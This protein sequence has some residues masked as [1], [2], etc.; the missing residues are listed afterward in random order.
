MTIVLGLH[1]ILGRMPSTGI[2]DAG[3]CVADPESGKILALVEAE[4]VSGIKHDSRLAP[5]LIREEL[6]A[7]G[8]EP[9]DVA[10]SHF[11][12]LN[13][14]SVPGPFPLFRE[15]DRLDKSCLGC[16]DVR[17]GMVA[18]KRCSQ[19]L[20]LHELA[21]VFGSFMYRQADHDR[22]LGL[23]IEGCGSFAQNSLFLVEGDRTE[24]LGYNYPVLS[25]HF[26]H[27]WISDLA[28]DVS[29]EDREA[30]SAVPGKAM[31]L[32]AYGDPDRFLP[33]LREA[34]KPFEPGQYMN[35]RDAFCPQIEKMRLSWKDRADL[36]A[37]GQALFEETIEKLAV[38][39]RE[40]YGQLP[41]YYSGGCA[42]SIK[43]N[44]RLKQ[45][46]DHLVV[47]P[48]CGDDGLALGLASMHAFM[49]YGQRLDPL[50]HDSGLFS[51]VW[52]GFNLGIGLP[53]NEIDRV[54][55]WLSDGEIVAFC[56][57]LPEI[58]PRALCRRSLL[59]SPFDPRMREIINHIKQREYYRP[60]A[61]A[62]LDSAGQGII[63]D[64][65]PSH[66]MLFDAQVLP[67]IAEEI[68]SAL[69]VDGTV[70]YNTVPDNGSDIAKLIKRYSA[71][72]GRPPVLLNT[73]LNSRGHAVAATREQVMKETKCLNINH[74]V[75][76][77]RTYVLD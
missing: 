44:S 56:Q 23:V 8:S 70:R 65:F 14:H 35:Y 40:Q 1:G 66:H 21:H 12:V 54:A 33:V 37:A 74:L 30:R 22:F 5:G 27:Q 62:V 16:L 47:P 42:L 57:G 39:I 52:S 24:L 29:R 60:V 3:Y 51:R 58:G 17:M 53:D 45:I 26:F 61:P 63:F 28:F 18:G 31:A 19:Y 71:V 50:D 46:F 32:A 59:A 49:Q 72:S 36:C 75:M 15:I 64:Y 34:V 7:F 25:G 76:G 38:Q 68:P 2:H 55:R 9:V 69:H 11:T 6:S 13:D 4:R 48:N 67:G 77:D 41:V 73:S 10:V 20:Y 43:T